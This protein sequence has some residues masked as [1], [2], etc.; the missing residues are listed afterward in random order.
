MV[1]IHN[2]ERMVLEG[3]QL[4][5][6]NLPDLFLTALACFFGGEDIIERAQTYVSAAALQSEAP[7]L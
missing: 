7:P 2:T 4:R 6:W 3:N 1:V 5:D